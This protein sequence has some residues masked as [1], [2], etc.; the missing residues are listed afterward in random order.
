MLKV[1]GVFAFVALVNGYGLVP[2]SVPSF[3]SVHQVHSV[4]SYNSAVVQTARINN[5]FAYNTIQR[6]GY[7]PQPIVYYYYTYPTYS[8]DFAPPQPSYP[9]PVPSYPG[10]SV[11]PSFPG[12]YPGQIPGQIPGAYPGVVPQNPNRPPIEVEDPADNLPADFTQGGNNNNN[13]N[14]GDDDDDTVTIEANK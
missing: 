2:Y 7:A 4:P 6:H 10:V 8:Y 14:N 1:L 9:V 13:N 5:G 3:N 12:Q 11:I